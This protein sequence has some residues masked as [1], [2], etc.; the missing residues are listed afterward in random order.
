MFWRF[1]ETPFIGYF[2]KNIRKLFFKLE[3]PWFERFFVEPTSVSSMASRWRTIFG[4]TWHLN[5]SVC[6]LPQYQDFM[7]SQPEGSPWWSRLCRRCPW[8]APPRRVGRLWAR[9][10]A[11]RPFVQT[12][13]RSR[14]RTSPPV[15]WLKKTAAHNMQEEALVSSEDLNI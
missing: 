4:S 14:R 8:T 10:E 3:E 12:S 7:A 5:C 1:F 15:R 2:K 11:N 9:L 13:A 6:L